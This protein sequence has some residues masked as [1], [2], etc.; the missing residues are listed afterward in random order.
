[1]PQFS[2]PEGVYLTI[3]Q[4]VRA[5]F[6]G[7]TRALL[8][9]NR[10]FTQYAGVD[11]TI[12]TFDIPPVY[13]VERQRLTERGE[14]IPGMRLLNIY[15]YYREQDVVAGE[16]LAEALPSLPELDAV[17]VP[18][19][20][21]TVYYTAYR[22]AETGNDV[23]RDYRRSDG[24]VYLRAPAPGSTEAAR[25]LHAGRPAEPARPALAQATA[26]FHHWLRALAGEAE[27]IFVI[28]DNRHAAEQ[29]LPLPD[30]RFHILHLMHNIHVIDRRQWNSPLW[31]SY[32]LAA[33][34]DRTARRTGDPDQ[35]AAG[36]RRAAVRRD[37]Q[38][39]RRLQSGH[40]ARAPR[41]VA[42]AQARDLHH[43][44]AL[45]GPEAAR[46]RGARLLARGRRAPA[47][48]AADLR[49]GVVAG[50][51]SSV[52]SPSSVW[53]DNI[54]LCG[55]DPDAR[56]TLW[57]STGFLMTSGFEG[58]PLASLESLSRGCPVVSYD[59][60]YG[61]QE[62]ITD[63]VDGFLVPNGDQRAMADRIIAMID[64]PELVRSLSAAAL[65][66]AAQHDHRAFLRRLAPR[67][68]Q[69]GRAEARSGGV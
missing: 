21:G 35:A 47:G 4:S 6:G 46:P 48:Q 5:R 18:H 28:S 15:E 52:S 11:T 61:P 20:D 68:D 60:K 55:W 19:P 56:D 66:K 51:R 23:T 49:S 65:D 36:G 30:E 37:E 50:H 63:G 67:P 43:R 27:R 24:S 57:T 14:L 62:Q 59:I 29:L 3:S 40:A 16:P 8:M 33:R 25:A 69:G 39:V 13:P 7:Q 32:Q 9:R 1:M 17:D 42:R 64:N 54:E 58:Y 10:F 22:D 31:P 2:L 44:V 12:L 38:P 53:K 41:P 45:R 34:P 26:W